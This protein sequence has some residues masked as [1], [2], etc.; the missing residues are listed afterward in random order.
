MITQFL[1]GPFGPILTPP[2]DAYGNPADPAGDHHRPDHRLDGGPA[3]TG[4]TQPGCHH[5]DHDAARVHPV[6]R[7]P[8]C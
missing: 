1:G 7:P 8:P 2:L 5:G 6:L 4:Q 3:T